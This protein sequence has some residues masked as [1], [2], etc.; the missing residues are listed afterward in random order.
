[1][2]LPG[3]PFGSQ[4]AGRRDECLPTIAPTMAKRG[5]APGTT[6]DE[7]AIETEWTCRFELAPAQDH[8]GG[9][10]RCCFSMSW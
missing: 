9:A 5:N 10:P 4:N 3:D 2:W 6:A 1:M 7:D 8:R